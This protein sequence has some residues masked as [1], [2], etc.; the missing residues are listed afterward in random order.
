MEKI[1]EGQIQDL[2]FFEFV[3]YT[4]M[5]GKMRMVIEEIL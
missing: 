5:A 1:G 3:L 2:E 4:E